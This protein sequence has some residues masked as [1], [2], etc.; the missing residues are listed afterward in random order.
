MAGRLRCFQNGLCYYPV[1]SLE[2]GEHRHAVVSAIDT[3]GS[4]VRPSLFKLAD[5]KVVLCGVV[6]VDVDRIAGQPVAVGW[7]KL[8]SEPRIAMPV[9]VDQTDVWKV[10]LQPRGPGTTREVL[11]LRQKAGSEIT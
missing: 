11:L 1:Q 2:P 6:H 8:C 7:S 4:A 5:G 9:L 3:L 10:L